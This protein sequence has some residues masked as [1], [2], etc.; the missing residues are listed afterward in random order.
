MLFFGSEVVY[1]LKETARSKQ[2]QN[3]AGLGILAQC[4]LYFFWGG[5]GKTNFQKKI[6]SKF[7]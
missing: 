2:F 1:I 5:E 7:E 4:I 6:A 3:K